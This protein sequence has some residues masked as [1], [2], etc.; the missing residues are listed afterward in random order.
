MSLASTS[1]AMPS[2][3]LIVRFASG[4]TTISE[5]PVGSPSDAGLDLEGDTRGADVVGVHLAELIGPHL[6]DEGGAASETGDADD[7]VGRR[8]S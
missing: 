8:S 3:V 7:R 4:V 6:A 1:A 2:E 5:R